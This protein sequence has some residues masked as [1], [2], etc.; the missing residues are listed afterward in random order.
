MKRLI[1]WLF[2][3]NDVCAHTYRLTAN[4]GGDYSKTDC[5]KCGHIFHEQHG[6]FFSYWTDE[7]GREWK[8]IA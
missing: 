2:G 4:L 6:H 8:R 5:P 7:Q 1:Q 3:S